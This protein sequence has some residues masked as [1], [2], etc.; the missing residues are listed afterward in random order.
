MATFTENEMLRIVDLKHSGVVHML[1]IQRQFIQ[2]MTFCQIEGQNGIGLA[3]GCASS[4]IRIY[5]VTRESL[6]ETHQY[7]KHSLGI[8]QLHWD[9]NK[10]QLH[11][12][13]NNATYML[14]DYIW[15]KPIRSLQDAGSSFTLFKGQQNKALFASGSKIKVVNL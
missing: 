13:D 11:S 5:S 15:N 1:K 7:T 8:R 14:Y 12:L 9:A 6:K 4:N 10:N 2:E 3:I